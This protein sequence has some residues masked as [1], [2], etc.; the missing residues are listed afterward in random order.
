MQLKAER[1]GRISP[2]PTLLSRQSLLSE[3]STQTDSL[4]IPST[5]DLSTQTELSDSDESGNLVEPT[6]S[7]SELS[8]SSSLP[9]TSSSSSSSSPSSSSSSSGEEGTVEVS[10]RSSSGPAEKGKL[11]VNSVHS[12]G[13]ELEKRENS[14][15][16]RSSMAYLS[17]S[18]FN[19]INNGAEEG[20][21][22]QPPLI[23]PLTLRV[24]TEGKLRESKENF[25]KFIQTNDWLGHSM[26]DEV[27]GAIKNASCG[28]SAIQNYHPC[29]SSTG[30]AEP[31]FQGEGGLSDNLP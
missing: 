29:Y 2:L 7:S 10:R 30:S 28:S 25:E 8:I 4:S 11:S 13:L 12:C 6:S 20:Q 18:K 17:V 31:P 22:N 1:Q 27:D 5:C 19:D 3:S 21:I 15:E 24:Q 14:E 23:P 16:E 26:D 9:Q